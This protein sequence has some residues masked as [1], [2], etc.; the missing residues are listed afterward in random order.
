MK[1]SWKTERLK[2][3]IQ[4]TV[5]GCV[6]PCDVANVVQIVTSAGTQWFGGLREAD[7]DT[8]LEWARACSAAHAILPV[9]PAMMRHRFEGYLGEFLLVQRE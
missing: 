7:Y 9:P 1:T 3:T 5:S 4:L 6:G 8:L 2:R